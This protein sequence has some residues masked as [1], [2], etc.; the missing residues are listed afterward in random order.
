MKNFFTNY[1][2]VTVEPLKGTTLVSCTKEAL[3]LSKTLDTEVRFTFNE[4]PVVVNP[5]DEVNDILDRW[6]A[7]ESR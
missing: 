5:T 2:T 7:S 6:S 4:K 3:E 1:V